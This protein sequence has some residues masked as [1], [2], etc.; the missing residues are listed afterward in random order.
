VLSL[1]SVGPGTPNNQLEA[2]R[3]AA[4]GHVGSPRNCKFRPDNMNLPSLLPMSL[5][6]PRLRP[7]ARPSRRRLGSSVLRSP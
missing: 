7:S 1:L 6:P 3:I 2:K 5:P 4:Q